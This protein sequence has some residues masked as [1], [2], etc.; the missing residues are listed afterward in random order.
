[1]TKLV[2]DDQHRLLSRSRLALDMARSV[3]TEHSREWRR[4]MMERRTSLALVLLAIPVAF[5]AIVA[6]QEVAGVAGPMQALYPDGVGQVRSVVTDLVI[7]GSPALAFL[8][9]AT[10]VLEIRWRPGPESLLS[11]SVVRVG[12]IHYAILIGAALIGAVFAGYVVAENWECVFG[13]AIAC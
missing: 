10:K 11:I 4:R 5:L 8:M 9:A 1:M 7:V 13:S 6:L 3:P 12:W 2:E